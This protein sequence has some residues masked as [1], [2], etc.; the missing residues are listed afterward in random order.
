LRAAELRSGGR[1]VVCVPSLEDDG[2]HPLARLFDTANVALAEMV[3]EGVID[4][5]ERAGM[6][7]AAYPR[8]P[9]EML[10]PFENSGGRVPWRMI[11]S[12]FP[13]FDD[14]NW[15][16][17]CQDGD[18]AKLAARRAGFFRATFGP[19]LASALNVERERKAFAERLEAGMRHRLTDVLA[20]IPNRVAILSLVRE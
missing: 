13:S 19:S 1:L 16:T 10:A 7:I 5:D 3:N 8:T 9:A 18:V 4:A 6:C 20:P 15:T 14:R 12:S 11:S 2:S 17:Y